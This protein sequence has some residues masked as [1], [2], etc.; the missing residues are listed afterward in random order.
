MTVA[1]QILFMKKKKNFFSIP[2]LRGNFVD[3]EGRTSRLTM[4]NMLASMP[5]FNREKCGN[6][7]KIIAPGMIIQPV[8]YKYSP[9]ANYFRTRPFQHRVPTNVQSCSDLCPKIRLFD[10]FCALPPHRHE[11]VISRCSTLI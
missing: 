9:L 10:H 11:N 4:T 5:I 1:I 3:V 6:A 8:S 2:P 7:T